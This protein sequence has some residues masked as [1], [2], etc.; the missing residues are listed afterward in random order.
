MRDANRIYP[1]CIQFAE[2]WAK[3]PD[4]RF[5]QIV[6]N[7]ARY[8]QMKYRKDAFFLEEDEIMDIIKKMLK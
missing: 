7:V 8:T 4:L 1:F 3:H 6:S 2:L 5:G